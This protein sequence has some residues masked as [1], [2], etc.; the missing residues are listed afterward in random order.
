MNDYLRGK[1]ESYCYQVNRGKPAA[2]L[3]VKE[4]YL[5]E[6]KRLIKSHSLKLINKDLSQ[7]WTTVW[8]Y[9]H[10]HLKEIINKL[11]QA[12]ESKFDHWVLGKL[13]GYSEIEIGNYINQL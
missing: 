5:E 3:P 2:A 11:Q 13:F 6:T 7:N 12:P 8:I 10:G 1:I 9:K 4:K